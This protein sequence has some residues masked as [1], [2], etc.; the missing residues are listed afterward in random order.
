VG[1]WEMYWHINGDPPGNEGPYF[2]ANGSYD[3][4]NQ[5]A[6]VT[7][8]P[9]ITLCKPLGSYSYNGST[10]TLAAEDGGGPT[11]T[12]PIIISGDTLTEPLEGGLVT[13]LNY[14]RENSTGCDCDD[15]GH[16]RQDPTT[17]RVDLP[18]DRSNRLCRRHDRVDRQYDRLCRRHDRVDRQCDRLCR[19]HDRVDRQCD[20]LCRRHDR[21]DRQCDRLC[22]RSNRSCSKSNRLSLIDDR[23]CRRGNRSGRTICDVS[24][25]PM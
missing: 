19:R 10:V 14:T 4:W 22:S 13:S 9:Q 23:S 18:V 2:N 6:I 16:C 7:G 25:S 17:H 5:F 11:Y 8:G 3:S 12:V 1:V 20:R 24:R 15:A 21:V